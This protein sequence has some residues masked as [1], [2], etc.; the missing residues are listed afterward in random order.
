MTTKKKLWN[1]VHGLHVHASRWHQGV[2]TTPENIITYHN[3]F[4]LSPQNFAYALF[5]V[6]LGAV[7]TPKRNWRQ[8]LSKILGWQTKSIM[9]CYGIFWSGQLLKALNLMGW[10]SG[11]AALNFAGTTQLTSGK[12]SFALLLVRFY[13][14]VVD[15]CLQAAVKCDPQGL[16]LHFYRN[17]EPHGDVQG[18][19]A[20]LAR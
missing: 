20:F 15:L 12:C 13:E 18:E 11:E 2:L 1:V 10:H 16:A 7:L 3:A 14:G 17:G 9:V 19:E 6:S 5:S 8:W 4:C